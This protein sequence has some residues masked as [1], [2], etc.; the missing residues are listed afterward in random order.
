MLDEAHHFLPLPGEPDAFVLPRWV[1][2]LLMA[3]VNPE[4]VSPTAL[5][6]ADMVVTFGDAASSALER[7]CQAIGELPPDQAPAKVPTGQA[8]AFDRTGGSRLVQFEIAGGQTE[9]RPH[10]RRYAESELDEAKSFYFRGEDGRLRLRPSTWP[11]SS[12]SPR[13]WTMPPGC[14]TSAEATTRPGSWP[15]PT[16][17]RWPSK[18]P[19]S[20]GKE[21]SCRPRRADGASSPPSRTA[22]WRTH[23]RLGLARSRSVELLVIRHGQSE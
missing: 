1:D 19:R 21:R 5:S 20:S 12:T 22:I 13:G 23:D 14:T 7:Y 8:L 3:T 18:P 4:H 11:C 10:L 2:G 9:R 16:M 15:L 17:S 6:L